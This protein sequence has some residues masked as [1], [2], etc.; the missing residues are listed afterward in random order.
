MKMAFG[1]DDFQIN[2]FNMSV[3]GEVY[4]ESFNFTFHG[5]GKFGKYFLSTIV[6]R[7]KSLCIV[8]TL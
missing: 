2:F 5:I 1:I 4:G 8:N 3:N 7:F 6:T